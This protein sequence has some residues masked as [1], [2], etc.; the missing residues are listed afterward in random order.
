MNNEI[1][2]EFGFRI[3]LRIMLISEAIIH[4]GQ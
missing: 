4:L 3:T 1:I 2:I